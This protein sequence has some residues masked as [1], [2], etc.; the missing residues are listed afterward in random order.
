MTYAF[1]WALQQALHAALTADPTVAD[2]AGGRVWDALP[3]DAEPGVHVLIGEES[4]EPWSTATERGAVH[5]TTVS[6]LGEARSFGDMKRLAGAVCDAAT[7]LTTLASGHV[8]NA[9]FEGGRARR[10][11]AREPRRIDLRFRFTVEE[12]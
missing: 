1:S 3:P 12:A 7:R 11:T 5:E 10:E 2:V 4:V 9:R 8:V 6:V